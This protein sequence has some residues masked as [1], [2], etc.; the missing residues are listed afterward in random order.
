MII[1]INENDHLKR[2]KKNSG[3]FRSLK[4]KL[5]HRI[6]EGL[7]F[8]LVDK[9]GVLTLVDDNEIWT[10]CWGIKLRHMISLKALDFK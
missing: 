8:K 10:N 1:L 3:I 5:G 6:S 2:D 4:I 9:Y 7:D